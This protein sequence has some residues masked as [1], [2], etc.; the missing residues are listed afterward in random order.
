M[1]DKIQ[2]SDSERMQIG[3]KANTNVICGQCQKEVLGKEA[4]AYKDVKNN[5][6]FLCEPCRNEAE[7]VLKAET[8]N[9][10]IVMAL[11]LG[12]IAGIVAGVIWYFFSSRR[13]HT[14]CA[15]VTGVQTCA[16]PISHIAL[17]FLQGVGKTTG[18]VRHLCR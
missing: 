8:Q 3:S 15:L 1:D 5:E 9:P 11:L 6:I 18:I 10:N 4:Y 17:Y 14:R 16:L 13:R 12:S 2:N 7:K